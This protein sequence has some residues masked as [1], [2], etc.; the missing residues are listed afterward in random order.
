MKYFWL[1]SLIYVG[2]I[3]S[4]KSMRALFMRLPDHKCKDVKQINTK[5]LLH[6]PDNNTLFNAQWFVLDQVDN[7]KEDTLYKKTLWDENYVL[8]KKGS[9]YYVLKDDCSHRGASLA[10]G[11]L[12]TNCVVCPYHGYEFNST[13]FLVK[14]PG[15]NYTNSPSIHNQKDYPVIEKNGWI[16]MNTNTKLEAKLMNIHTYDLFSEPEANN[17]NFT[18][19]F[20]EQTFNNYARIVTENSLDIMHIG[21][22]HSFGNAR[23][24]SPTAEFGPYMVNNNSNHYKITYHYKTGDNSIIKRVFN[25]NELKIENEFILPQTTVAR[26]IFGNYTSTIITSTLPINNTHSNLF[27]KT[28]RDYWYFPDKTVLFGILEN[29]IEYI[30]NVLTGITMKNTIDEDKR[31]IDNIKPKYMDG[32]YNMKYDKLANLY[33]NLYKKRV[34][35]KKKD[36]IF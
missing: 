27:V 10:L 14:I 7:I 11:H 18:S 34:E 8:W 29:L 24:P 19:M 15:L 5:E 1:L 22:V 12:S 17:V 9:E 32:N 35:D 28:Y 33:R 6:N 13:G 36:N 25:I 3:F 4:F 21:F 23:H 31:I 2:E 16:Y 20:I 30:G 26:V